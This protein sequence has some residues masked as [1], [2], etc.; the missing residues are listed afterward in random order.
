[1]VETTHAEQVAA[2][3]RFSRLYTREIGVLYE[4]LL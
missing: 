2:V 3:R 1:M 4:G